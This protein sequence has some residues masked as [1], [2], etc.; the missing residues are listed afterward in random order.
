[1]YLRAGYS[2]DDYPT[3]A[4]WDARQKLERSSAAKCPS[5]AFQLAGA[6]KVV[7]VRLQQSPRTRAFHCNAR[8]PMLEGRIRIS[9]RQ[10]CNLML[11]RRSSRTW[12]GQACWSASCT[13]TQT[14]SSCAPAL[15]VSR[16]IAN[17]HRHDMLVCLLH[18]LR[19]SDAVRVRTGV[20]AHA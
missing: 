10:H 3:E 19:H 13:A 15:R 6:K 9:H 18:C 4:H 20:P 8:W 2:P 14:Y 12:R 7:L 16:A 1:M 11:R 17:V 5:V